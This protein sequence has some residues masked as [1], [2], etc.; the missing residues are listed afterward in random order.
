M[1]VAHR[2]TPIKLSWALGN[3]T[4]LFGTTNN[5]IVS[6]AIGGAIPVTMGKT[7]WLV[8]KP[9]T[10]NT[11]DEWNLT[12]PPI[13]GTLAFSPDDSMWVGPCPTAWC[14]LGPRRSDLDG[15]A[16]AFPNLN[17]FWAIGP[18]KTGAMSEEGLCSGLPRLPVGFGESGV[19]KAV[20]IVRVFTLRK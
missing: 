12:S 20:K 1:P 10:T 11:S 17:R 14:W 9:G 18:P 16:A 13:L 4:A 19:D 15:S 3:P 2:T 5:S 7:Y 8:L 6:F